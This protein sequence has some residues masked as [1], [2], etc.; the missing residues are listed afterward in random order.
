M[1]KC[2]M[3]LEGVYR[4]SMYI[5]GEFKNIVVYHVTKEQFYTALERN[6]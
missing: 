5:K 2:G 3:T 1:Q 4:H 6:A